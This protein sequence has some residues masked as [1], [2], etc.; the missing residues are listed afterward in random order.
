MLQLFPYLAELAAIV[1]TADGDKQAFWTGYQ[2]HFNGI[3]QL[4]LL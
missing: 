3:Q 4:R 1:A 2:R